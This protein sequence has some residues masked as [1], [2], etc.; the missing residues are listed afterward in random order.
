MEGCREHSNE[1]SSSVYY[2]EILRDSE[3]LGNLC[4]VEMCRARV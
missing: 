2:T 3:L 1:S 4:Y